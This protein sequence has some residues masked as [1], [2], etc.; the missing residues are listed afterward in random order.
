MGSSKVAALFLAI[1]A[2]LLDY[3]G[4]TDRHKKSANAI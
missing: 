1:E 4:N 2:V 3:S